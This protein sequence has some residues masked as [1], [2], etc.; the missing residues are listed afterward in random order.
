[1]AQSGQMKNFFAMSSEPTEHDEEVETFCPELS[2]FS[3]HG[4]QF[5]M[6]LTEMRPSTR[7][8]DSV[9]ELLS[10]SAVDEPLT[11][12]AWKVHPTGAPA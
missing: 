1:M 2:G 9:R 7:V 11:A 12:G 6:G 10:G 5:S 3:A 8:S 4:V